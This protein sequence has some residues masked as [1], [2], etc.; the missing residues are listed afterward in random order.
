MEPIVTGLSIAWNWVGGIIT[1][2]SNTIFQWAGIIFAYFLGKKHAKI[3]RLEEDA[4]IKDE[5]LEIAS[6]PPTHADDLRNRMRDGK[7]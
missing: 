3:E 1:G 4:K 2:I 7:L 5:Q 6:R